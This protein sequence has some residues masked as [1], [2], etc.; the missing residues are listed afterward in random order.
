MHATDVMSVER[1]MAQHAL[2]V[3]RSTPSPHPA[4]PPVPAHAGASLA[5]WCPTCR[6][7]PAC[8]VAWWRSLV[9]PP[10]GHSVGGGDPPQRPTNSI[11]GWLPTGRRSRRMSETRRW[12]WVVAPAAGVCF[13][14]TSLKGVDMLKFGMV[15]EINNGD[16]IRAT[17]MQCPP[18]P[19][20]M[21][22]ATQSLVEQASWEGDGKVTRYILE[23]IS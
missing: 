23:R 12:R 16:E 15:Y 11:A 7:C 3:S 20:A 1:D 17:T 4:R 5:V 14:P 2:G 22:L 6:T 9:R 10:L 13:H 19:A 8:R 21:C 18:N